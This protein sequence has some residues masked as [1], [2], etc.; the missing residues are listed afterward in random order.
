[1]WTWPE[2]S[3]NNNER[4]CPPPCTC[5]QFLK[6]TRGH[7]LYKVWG[8]IVPSLWFQIQ[9]QF[10]AKSCVS[11]DRS[12]GFAKTYFPDT[13]QP[14]F[15]ASRRSSKL[16]LEWPSTH[17]CSIQ[18][19]PFWDFLDVMKPNPRTGFW[20]HS[21]FFPIH[22]ALTFHGKFFFFFFFP[23]P[24]LYLPPTFPFLPLSPPFSRS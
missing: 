9:K 4:H 6:K 20:V 12:A 19:F 1:M 2:Q 5:R 10:T 11:M 17:Q 13:V 16:R 23:Q 8:K 22:P 3:Y 18:K 15:V 14:G 24:P 7:V 21:F